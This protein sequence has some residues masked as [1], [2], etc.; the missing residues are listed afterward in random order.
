M[1]CFQYVLSLFIIY[2]GFVCLCCLNLR[3]SIFVGRYICL[4]ITEKRFGYF[5]CIFSAIV[6]LLEALFVLQGGCARQMVF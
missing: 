4:T 3:R 2:V 1:G 5:R 6:Y